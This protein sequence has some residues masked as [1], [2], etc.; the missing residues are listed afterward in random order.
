MDGDKPGQAFISDPPVIFL[1]ACRHV[2]EVASIAAR[3]GSAA[4]RR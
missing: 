4:R 1:L 2:T 3:A